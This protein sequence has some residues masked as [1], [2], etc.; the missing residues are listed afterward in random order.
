MSIEYKPYMRQRLTVGQ[1]VG[2]EGTDWY[3]F[4]ECTLVG[5]TLETNIPVI[6]IGYEE[7]LV[8]DQLRLESKCESKPE[9]GRTSIENEILTKY[10]KI[11]VDQLVGKDIIAV[12]KGN[13]SCVIVTTDYEYVKLVAGS[14]DWGE[15]LGSKEDL[16]LF[17]LFKLKLIA[18]D[19]WQAHVREVEVNRKESR[20]EADERNLKHAVDQV[21][22]IEAA[23][24]TS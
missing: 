10:E 1:R 23:K 2:I 20:R 8:R 6:D 17:D 4:E 5:A 11:G 9:D 3:C 13:D 22:G 19:I 15:Y 21:G 14:N 12:D 7:M 16:T 24:K 18:E